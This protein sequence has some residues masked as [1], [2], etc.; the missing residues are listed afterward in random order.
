MSVPQYCIIYSIHIQSFTCQSWACN[1]IL[2]STICPSTSHIGQNLTKRG[3]NPALQWVHLGRGV[4]SMALR[5]LRWFRRRLSIKPPVYIYI[6]TY[7]IKAIQINA[8]YQISMNNNSVCLV[9][10][11]TKQ[12]HVR[13]LQYA[14]S[15]RSGVSS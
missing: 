13:G 14:P 7:M 1:V 3:S 12:P 8:G 10:S 5:P 6:F 11:L 15:T 2:S 4:N 9:Y